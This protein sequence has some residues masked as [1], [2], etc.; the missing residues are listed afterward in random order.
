MDPFWLKNGVQKIP[1]KKPN[2][3]IK[4][5]ELF[6]VKLFGSKFSNIFCDFGDNFIISDI[7]GE[8]ESTS[9]LQEIANDGT[10]ICLE[11]EPHNLVK[12]QK[13]LL[14]DVT[15]IENVNDKFFTVKS[16]L[17]KISGF[18]G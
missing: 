1:T 6:K 17:N 7:D 18:L 3:I 13:F 5:P 8:Q 12:G 10:F 4:N 11:N 9:I 16:V 2:N 14:N 15:G